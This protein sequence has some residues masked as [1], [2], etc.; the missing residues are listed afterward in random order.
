M[1]YF[2]A[3]FGLVIAVCIAQLLTHMSLELTI[4]LFS[5]DFMILGAELL[6]NRAN[7]SLVIIKLEGIEMAFNDAASSLVSPSLKAKGQE[8]IEWLNKF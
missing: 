5:I 1:K 8:I 4:V 2:W 6:K 7:K 3:A